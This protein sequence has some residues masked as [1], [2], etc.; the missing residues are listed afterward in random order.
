MSL[1]LVSVDLGAESGRVILGTLRGG[2]LV[3]EVVHRFP[4][5]ATEVN[6]TLRWNVVGFHGEILRGLSMVAARKVKVAGVSCDSWGVDYVLGR[7]DAPLVSQPFQYRDPRTERTFGATVR[8]IGAPAIFAE[9]GVMFMGINTLYQL[10]DD[11]R[12]RPELLKVAHRFLNI[13][14]YFNWL[15]SGVPRAEVS[16]AST[17]QLWN[18]R[19]RTWSSKLIRDLQ[20]P[21]HL[22]PLVVPSG[23]VLGKTRGVRGLESAKVIASCSHDTGCAVA[24]VPTQAGDDWA[25]LSSGTWSLLG[26]ELPKPLINE[27]VR[28][29]NLTNEAGFG[30]TTRFLKVLVGLWI[31]QECRRE[32][33]RS[34]GPTDYAVIAKLAAK[35]PALR[36]LIRPDDARFAAPG[37]MVRKIQSFC[38]ETRQPVPTSPGAI[39]RCILESLA[40]LYQSEVETIE[41]LTGRDIRR[42]HVVGGGS[43]ND[44]LNQ[45]TADALGRTVI[46]GPTEATAAGNLLIQAHALGKVRGLAGIR[47]VVRASFPVQAF[48]PS[49]AHRAAW[50][51]ARARFA[52]LRTDRRSR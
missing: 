5:G 45:A 18:P 46:A 43:R 30:G 14:D 38:R 27:E 28:A 40:L 50:D 3:M 39:A 47:K 44:L 42:L 26:I 34:G 16:L 21:G 1:H 13:G 22:F 29:A 12:S 51:E 32:W 23:T 6:G 4:T 2:K 9:T 19:R 41:R 24:A 35:A 17:T 8:K 36:S 25:Y 48:K 49:R 20:L 33:E 15:L 31:L 37:D 10:V 11:V 7:D 52:A